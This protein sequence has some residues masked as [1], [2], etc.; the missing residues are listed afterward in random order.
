MKYLT[1][2]C[3]KNIDYLDKLI[4]DYKSST[5]QDEIKAAAI[6]SQVVSRLWIKRFYRD[7]ETT[8]T[9]IEVCI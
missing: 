9:H 3:P 2:N 1:T 8:F 7:A 5:A 4:H 6:F